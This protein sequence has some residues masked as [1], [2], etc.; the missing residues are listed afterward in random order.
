MGKTILHIVG[1]DNC[2]T[3]NDGTSEGKNPDSL[4]VKKAI[5][6]GGLSIKGENNF[7]YLFTLEKNANEFHDYLQEHQRYFP[8]TFKRHQFVL[9][10]DFKK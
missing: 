3:F 2:L 10:F 9:N 4:A 7:N 8:E 5:E 6:L 1:F